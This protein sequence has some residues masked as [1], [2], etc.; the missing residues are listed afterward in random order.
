MVDQVR[1]AAGR[2]A[3]RRL[4]VDDHRWRFLVG[5]RLLSSLFEELHACCELCLLIEGAA[6]SVGG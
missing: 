2:G 6:R 1:V 5:H 4:T 3:L